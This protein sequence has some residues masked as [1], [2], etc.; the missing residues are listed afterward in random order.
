MAWQA[1]LIGH[2]ELTQNHSISNA[3][4]AARSKTKHMLT[5]LWHEEMRM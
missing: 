3:R 5:G 1:T 2:H 4:S